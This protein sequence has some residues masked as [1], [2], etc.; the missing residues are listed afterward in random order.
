MIYYITH[1]R[2]SMAAAIVKELDLHRRYG[3][4]DRNHLQRAY[5]KL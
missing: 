5:I 4:I 2:S 3:L 1:V